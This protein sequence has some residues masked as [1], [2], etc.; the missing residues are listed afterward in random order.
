MIVL[1]IVYASTFIRWEQ[2][3]FIREFWKGNI[4]M[5]KNKKLTVIDGETL[6]DMRIKPISFCIDSLLPQGISLLC[7]APK[8]GK[9]WL[10]LDW[11]V[12][13]AKGEEVWN[14]K[15][16]KGTT[17]YLCLED[18]LSRIQQRLNEITDDVPNNVFFATSSCSMSDGFA[19]QI[20]MFVAEH[21]DTVLVVIDTFQMIRSKNKD[22]TYANDYQEIEKLKRLANKLK[23][24]LL[25]V[26][27][28][29]KQGDNDPLN[30]ISGT[31]GISGA[32]D[33]TFI[34]DKS[35]RSQNNA[36]MICT[37][38]DIEY[39]E[40]ELNFSKE[41]H[42]WNLVSD[43]VESPEILLPEEMNSL[44]EFM[45]Q[46]IVF[47]GTNSEFT[48]EF[49][50]FCRKEI[51]AKALKQMMNKWRYE[52]ESNNVYFNSYRSNGKR[53]VNV[54]YMHDSDSSA[55]SDGNIIGAK[56]CVPFVT[57]DLDEPCQAT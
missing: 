35:K 56:T 46:K 6:M 53:F 44:I 48:E 23:I 20:E 16:A 39:R 32:V 33:T 22:T 45:K 2:F 54:H 52:L 40:L 12:R 36:T 8:I 4:T 14:F 42:M 34:L 41:N 19:E 27:H 47:K 10:V 3:L 21:K 24:S 30:K 43:S 11:C 38:R 15:T 18:N 50:S 17:L 57:C 51:S 1:N 37:G 31:T 25:L 9:S 26:H 7:G 49:N 29:R 5:S 55:V 28:L 13:I